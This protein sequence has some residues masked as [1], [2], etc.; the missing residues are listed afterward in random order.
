MTIVCRPMSDFFNFPLY[1]LCDD[2]SDMKDMS[3]FQCVRPQSICNPCKN[4]TND[5]EVSNQ[6][7]VTS[8]QKD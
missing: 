7:L 4:F 3:F 8:S 6:T 1:K 5:A 2:P